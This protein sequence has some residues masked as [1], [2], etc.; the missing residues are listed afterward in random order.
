M[1]GL[2]QIFVTDRYALLFYI[3]NVGMVHVGHVGVPPSN[4]SHC[5]KW[6]LPE[7][8]LVHKNPHCDMCTICV[9]TIC[10]Y[11]SSMRVEACITRLHTVSCLIITRTITFFYCMYNL[12][13]SC[14]CTELHALIVAHITEGRK[15]VTKK[16]HIG[17]TFIL[18]LQF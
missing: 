10:D 13:Y 4:C 18:P 2:E 7:W 12:S 15:G 11:R 17:I 16:S 8:Q 1:F 5:N 14:I 9:T 3:G 6:K